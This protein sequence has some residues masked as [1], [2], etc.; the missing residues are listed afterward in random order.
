MKWTFKRMLIALKQ[1]SNFDFKNN[2]MQ[3]FIK[4]KTL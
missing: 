4:L 1:S 3:I 2:F